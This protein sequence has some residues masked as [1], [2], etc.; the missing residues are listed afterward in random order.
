M[1]LIAR[2]GREEEE[3]WNA[4]ETEA[5]GRQALNMA[6]RVHTTLGPGLLESVY[7]SAL[8][9]EF[10]KLGISHARQVPI[11]VLYDGALLEEVGFR[12]DIILNGLVLLELKAT[13]DLLPVHLKVTT[14][15]LR[16]TGLKLGFLINFNSPRLKDGIKR[17]THGLEGKRHTTRP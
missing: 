17:V 13:A 9:H 15:Y 11:P 10:R 1:S 3:G 14:T 5:L 4:A 6:F 7:E 8:C 12:A 16:L 2:E